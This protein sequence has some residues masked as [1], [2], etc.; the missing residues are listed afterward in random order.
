MSTCLVITSSSS[1]SVPHSQHP[2]S[3]G[4]I[5]KGTGVGH[6]LTCLTAGVDFGEKCSR[7]KDNMGTQ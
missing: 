5:C 2:S 3:R 4:V 6:L 1:I 7:L